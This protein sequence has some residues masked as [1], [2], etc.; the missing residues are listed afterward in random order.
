[1]D[2]FFGADALRRLVLRLQIGLANIVYNVKAADR[3]RTLGRA[4]RLIEATGASP[5][6]TAT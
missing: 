6:H 4:S 5:D 2:P 3:S 1:V